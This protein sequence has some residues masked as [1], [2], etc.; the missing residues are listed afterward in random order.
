[1]SSLRNILTTWHR[2]AQPEKAVLATLVKVQGSSYRKPGARFLIT[3]TG[4]VGAVSGG[5]LEQDLVQKARTLGSTAEVAVFDM[6]GEGD[7]LW[8][9]AEGCNG[10]LHILLERLGTTGSRP[11]ELMEEVY[12]RRSPGVIA[13]VI[14]VQGELKVA[15]GSRVLVFPGGRIQET[16]LNPF[17]V[18]ALA[19]HAAET[20]NGSS[21][22]R[23]FQ[24]TEGAI[25]VFFEA[26]PP[27]ISLTILGAG[28][29]AVPVCR[30]AQELGWD[31]TVID[32][33]PALAVEERFPGARVAVV[34]PETITK[35]LN[36]DRRSAVVI[37]TH[38]LR[39]DRIYLPAVL[40]RPFAYVGLLGSRDR[41]KALLGQ[42]ER[43]GTPVK[44]SDRSRI[45]TPAG[46]DIGSES[47]E[48]IALAI[49]SEIQT[50]MQNRNGGLLRNSSGT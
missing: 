21:H 16:I 30:I 49:V 6:T 39:H 35:Q 11:L 17:V 7:E 13:T 3:E 38:S 25:E 29:D 14:Q 18:S 10:V 1:M 8:G 40:A 4:T 46:L 33:R 48:E 15:V 20:L 22:I 34:E 42:L 31:L 24:F 27:P 44:E 9:Y 37:M 36:A 23:R 5:C 41:F 26:V 45:H 50:V 43:A 47:P 12:R 19:E 32:H 2:L 28:D